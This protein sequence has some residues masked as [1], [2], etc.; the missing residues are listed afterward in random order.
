M[1]FRGVE[2]TEMRQLVRSKRITVTATLQED[3]AQGRIDVRQL[4]LMRVGPLK[5]AKPG[6]RNPP[7]P[8]ARIRQLHHDIKELA[9]RSPDE[10]D[11]GKDRRIKRHAGQH[12]G[13]AKTPGEWLKTAKGIFEPHERRRTR[14]SRGAIRRNRSARPRCS[15]IRG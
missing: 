14:R 15:Q 2:T 13:N 1:I 8:Q 5:G 3:Q 12:R 11:R 10:N 9:E 6:S 4:V 7:H